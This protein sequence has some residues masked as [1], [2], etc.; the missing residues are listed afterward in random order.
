M[1]YVLTGVRGAGKTTL[2]DRMRD[3]GHLILQPSTTRLPRFDGEKEYEFVS[4]WPTDRYAWTI[5]VGGHQ[6]G[7]RKSEIER[8]TDVLA[9]TVFE[10][11]AIQTFYEYRRRSEI[12]SLT[13][14]L[15]TV[16]TVAEQHIRVGMSAPRMMSMEQ[17]DL[18]RQN[19]RDADICLD[20]DEKQILAKIKDLFSRH[21]T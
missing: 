20:G 7:V 6:Y 12:S 3:D 17:F 9:F 4:T 15:D 21:Q 2:I 1:L 13:I 10:P 11:A 19:V 8:A 18:A 16:A 14:G 5:Q